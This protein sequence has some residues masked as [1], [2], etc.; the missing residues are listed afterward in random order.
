MW[1]SEENLIFP[2]E[3]QLAGSIWR[4][5]KNSPKFEEISKLWLTVYVLELWNLSIVLLYISWYNFGGSFCRPEEIFEE[6]ASVDLRFHGVIHLEGQSAK[7]SCVLIRMGRRIPATN[8]SLYLLLTSL[9]PFTL[10]NVCFQQF[11]LSCCQDHPAT[12]QQDH[13]SIMP[14]ATQIS[15]HVFVTNSL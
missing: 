13:A 1:G 14:N 6:N 5:T 7:K 10:F 8:E 3:N 11:A 12:K 4:K 2:E 9:L 15:M